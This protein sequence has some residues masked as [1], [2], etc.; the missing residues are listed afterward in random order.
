MDMALFGLLLMVFGGPLDAA[1]TEADLAGVGIDAEDLDFEILSDIDDILRGLDLNLSMEGYKLLSRTLALA[2][3]LR[4]QINSTGVFRVLE[5]PD[6]L[7]EQV[8]H[9]GI[10]LDPTPTL[11]TLQQ[12]SAVLVYSNCA[13]NNSA[14]LGDV[15]A[16]YVDGGGHVVV[17]TFSFWQEWGAR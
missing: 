10:R 2:K 13:F 1:E 9:D 14:A 16:D 4:Q 5:L 6:L 7:P 12:Y 17:A 15:L 3:E 8:R 11:A